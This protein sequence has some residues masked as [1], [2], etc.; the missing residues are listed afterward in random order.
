MNSTDPCQPCFSCGAIVPDWDGPTHRYMESS[1][2]CWKIYGDVLAREYEDPAFWP[3]HR[4]TVDSYAL[5]HPGQ[6]SSQTIQSNRL[7]LM[8]LCL[9][10]ERGAD[11]IFVSR[12]IKLWAQDQGDYEWLAPPSSLGDFTVADVVGASSATNHLARVRQW[13]SSVWAAW[14]DYHP[15]VREWVDA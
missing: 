10:L 2:G 7:H 15:I 8:S 14:S 1:A 3:L 11:Q 13:S 9:F 4:L 5:Q 12:M 6:S